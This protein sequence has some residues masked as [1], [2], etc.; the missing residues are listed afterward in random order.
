MKC[1]AAI[2]VEL[3]KPLV[4]EEIEIPALKFGQVLVQIVCSG[5]CGSQIGEIN[6]A[7]GPDNYLPHLLGHEGLGV[8]KECG[9]GVRTVAPGDRVVLHWRPGAGMPCVPA[10]YASKLGTINAGW[11][12]TFNE[13][14]VIAENRMTKV[15]ADFDPEVGA[16]MGCAVTTGFGVINNNAQLKIG[17]SIVVFGAG[18]I[19]LNIIQAAAMVSGNPIIAVDFYDNRLELA[20]S[21]GATHLINSRNVNAEEAVRALVGKD[22]ADV[23]VDNTGNVK[24]I[25]LAYRLTSGSGRTVLVGVPP[26]GSEATIYTLPLHFE[27]EL[28]GSH[29]GESHPDHDIPRYVNLCKTGKLR[30]KE[31]VGKRYRLEE[32]NQ[33]IQDMQS[34]E[35]AGRCLIHM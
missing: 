10:K 16:L 8:V 6:G 19:G 21:L 26:K 22:G 35:V 27:K 11:V 1:R 15:P 32:I 7:K 25:E 18:G 20:K 28:T 34:G 33:A 12:T 2:L 14:A 31:L 29:G 24:V 17:E 3:K 9:E 30:L 13:F 4:I 23:A 5:L